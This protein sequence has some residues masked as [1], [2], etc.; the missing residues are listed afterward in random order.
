MK[1]VYLVRHAKSDW[2]RIGLA[3]R[4]RPLNKRGK[5]DAP[6]MG[7]RL[8]ARGVKPDLI[9]TSPAK[10]ARKTAKVF[11]KELGYPKDEIVVEERVYEG[12]V[13]DLWDIIR[14]TDDT[15]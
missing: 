5:R 3:D 10:R 6:V 13:E 14:G 4:D 15:H 2:K 12:G 11:A 9:V 8:A 7:Q 1:R